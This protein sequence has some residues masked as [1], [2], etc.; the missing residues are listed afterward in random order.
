M[1][2]KSQRIIRVF[3]ET[4]TINH[5]NHLAIAGCDTIELA[6]SFGTPLYVFDETTLRNKCREYTR[7]FNR[8][9]S[10]VTVA[11]ACKAYANPALVTV[12]HEEGLWLDAVSGGEM[13]I[14]RFAGFPPE[15]V[16]FHGNNKTQDELEFALDWSIGRVV[17][18]N[19]REMGLLQN[20]AAKRQRIQQVL[21]R[22]SP[23]VDPHTHSHTTT[24]VL[25]SKFGFPISTGQ[26]EEAIA[27]AIRSSNLRLAGLHF[28][29]GSPLFEVEPY[30]Q[31]IKI[32]LEFA[33]RISRNYDFT[34]DELD[35]GGGFA[36]Q[37]LAEKPAP[38]ASAY[39]EVI[40]RSILELT[41]Q[42]DMPLPRLIIEPGRAII[43]Q[44]GIA[45]YR[46]GGNKTIQGVRKYVFVDGGMGD[47][48]RPPLYDARYEAMVAN[49]AASAPEEKVTI[50]GKFCESGDI[51]I[52]DIDLPAIQDGDI[53]AVPVC[54][55]YCLAMSSNYNAYLK[56]AVI[57]VSEGQAKLMR[58]RETYAD[59][60]RQ[61]LF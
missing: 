41:S 47:N 60:V 6:E 7:E 13:N 16:L 10:D 22:L 24:G 5:H 30:E 50:A 35:V 28:H 42:L 37:Y 18:D 8:V 29:L 34:L 9:Y 49:K 27:I 12:L 23:E 54:G 53:I 57:L 21:L 38:P 36:V 20:L 55:A 40:A 58:R 25:D 14:A 52:R 19:F 17:V 59:L 11:Y 33:S 45:L 48:I 39:A 31:A 26:A 32:V 44:A 4:A 1:S 43:G 61:D 51:L 3:P 2:D 46:A 15:K 56:P